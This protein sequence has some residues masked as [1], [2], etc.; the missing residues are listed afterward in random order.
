MISLAVLFGCWFVIFRLMTAKSAKH[1]KV[2]TFLIATGIQFVNRF[3]SIVLKV[4]AQ[5]GLYDTVGE[6]DYN[7]IWKTVTAQF[8]NTTIVTFIIKYFAF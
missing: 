7:M 3:V 5:K 4:S 6:Q 1:S 8:L 2:R